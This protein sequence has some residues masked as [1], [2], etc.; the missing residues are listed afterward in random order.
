[1]LVVLEAMGFTDEEF[2]ALGV[3]RQTVIQIKQAFEAGGTIEEV[4]TLIS[5]AMVD[6]GFIAGTP[7]DCI[8]PLEE[9]CASAQEYGFDQIC[10]AK[11]GPDYEEA[12]AMLSR[13]LLPSIVRAS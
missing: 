5:D 3:E 10:L 11:L 9:M 6:I 8:K 2:D 12:I 13:Q 4:A 7:H 1:M